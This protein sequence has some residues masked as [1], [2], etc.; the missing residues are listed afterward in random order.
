MGVFIG[1]SQALGYMGQ[2]VGVNGSRGLRG[3]GTFIKKYMG[4]I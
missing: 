1:L 4:L 2:M 3:F